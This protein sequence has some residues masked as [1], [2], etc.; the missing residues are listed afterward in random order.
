MSEQEQSYLLEARDLYRTYKVG[1][2]DVEVLKGVSLKVAR[3]ETLSIRGASGAGKSTLLHA[4][5]GIEK[6]TRGRVLFEGRDVYGLSGRARTELRA[7]EIGFVFQFYYL[8]PELDVLENVALPAL[9]R[10]G[11]LRSMKKWHEKA[12]D[13]LD[14]VGLA[15]RAK[16]LPTELSG[17]EQQRVALARALMN[18]PQIVLADEPT[19]N[20]DSET[21]AQVLDHLFALIEE[22]HGGLILVSHDE[23]VAGRCRRMLYLRDGVIV[24]S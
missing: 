24:S 2:A 14:R 18:D 23:N 7:T 12:H 16:H 6:P 22:S 4:L 21:G 10:R 20:L 19:G 13:L 3:G 5:G 11:A 15:D 17:G 1:R 8:L 9:S